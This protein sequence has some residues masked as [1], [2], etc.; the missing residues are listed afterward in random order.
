M[1]WIAAGF[2]AGGVLGTVL[3]FWAG[4][5]QWHPRWHTQTPRELVTLGVVLVVAVG[6]WAVLIHLSS[7][8]WALAATLPLSVY[9]P[10][11]LVFVA[12]DKPGGV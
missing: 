6:G 12:T 11:L 7:H 2:A 8:P 4:I 5:N 9:L 1:S 3:L 10:A